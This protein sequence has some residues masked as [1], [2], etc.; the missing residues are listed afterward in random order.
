MLPLPRRAQI[1]AL[2]SLDGWY[3]SMGIE[4]LIDKRREDILE[5]AAKHGARNVRIFWSVARGEADANSDLDILV[6][7]RPDATQLSHR[8]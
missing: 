5:V 8:L 4:G 6:E 3:V 7:F 1:E 2:S